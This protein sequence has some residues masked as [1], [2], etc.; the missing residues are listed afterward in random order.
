ESKRVVHRCQHR[1]QRLVWQGLEY[2]ESYF[3]NWFRRSGRSSRDPTGAKVVF[4][5]LFLA[6]EAESRLNAGSLPK[7]D[8]RC[9]VAQFTERRRTTLAAPMDNGQPSPK[10]ERCSRIAV[11]SSSAR[12]SGASVVAERLSAFTVSRVEKAS[13]PNRWIATSGAR[14][15]SAQIT[16]KNGGDDGTRTRGLCRDRA[17][18]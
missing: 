3:G 1:C 17:A 2:T 15:R 14:I 6:I 16:E 12:C 8:L 18:F 11:F 9:M 4:L 7:S 13:E 10:A 5:A